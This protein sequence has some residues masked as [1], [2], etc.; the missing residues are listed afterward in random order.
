MELRRVF[1]R[2]TLILNGFGE[3]DYHSTVVRGRPEPHIGNQGTQN[4]AGLYEKDGDSEEE[5]HD[6]QGASPHT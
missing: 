6:S 5:R 1:Q 3:I 2:G 4:G